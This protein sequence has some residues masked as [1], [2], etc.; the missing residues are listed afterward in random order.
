M[1]VEAI[2]LSDVI[3]E[4]KIGLSA[5]CLGLEQLAVWGCHS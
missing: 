2:Q 5:M 1:Q 4:R 3:G